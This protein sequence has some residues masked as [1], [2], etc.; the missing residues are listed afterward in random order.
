MWMCSVHSSCFV[1][2]AVPHRPIII[3]NLKIVLPVMM[4]FGKYNAALL[5]CPQ[6]L[7]SVWRW[8]SSALG[9]GWA[10]VWCKVAPSITTV[11][12][13]KRRED[14]RGPRAASVHPDVCV[15][16]KAASL[17]VQCFR[18]PAGRLQGPFATRRSSRA[19][20][21]KRFDRFIVS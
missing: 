5:F 17:F 8:H 10:S 9:L 7:C 1:F 21:V 4:F 3:C 13:R 15:G 6:S 12:S 11:H 14:N 19:S 2:Q 18:L 20:F 16:S